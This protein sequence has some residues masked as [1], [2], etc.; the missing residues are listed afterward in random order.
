M[1]ATEDTLHTHA[2]DERTHTSPDTQHVPDVTKREQPAPPQTPAH[3]DTASF[4][5]DIYARA[6]KKKPSFFSRLFGKKRTSDVSSRPPSTKDE[7]DT[8]PSDAKAH[9][10]AS[11]TPEDDARAI[12][13]LVR[14]EKPSLV[15]RIADAK[16]STRDATAA[17]AS[18]AS[19]TPTDAPE[20]DKTSAPTVKQKEVREYPTSD[21]H[22][23]IAR[24]TQNTGQATVILGLSATVLLVL[25]V[26]GFLF[27]FPGA[28]IT[29]FG[30]LAVVG[31]VLFVLNL[32][33]TLIGEQGIK[34]E[35]KVRK[36]ME[37]TWQCPRCGGYNRISEDPNAGRACE[38]C[39]YTE[40]HKE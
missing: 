6:T 15:E 22:A 1:N 29:V 26:V 5:E 14:G 3:D 9:N 19:T 31:L 23:A 13:A 21:E 36:S 28:L 27:D 2:Y 33:V 18:D 25:T 35:K 37:N 4:N 39:G 30:V 7:P 38:F 8:P 12:N 20:T 32:V 34:K 24:E 40:Q 11:L 10:I 16:R 17:P